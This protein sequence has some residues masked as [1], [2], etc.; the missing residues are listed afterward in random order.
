MPT[1]DESSGDDEDTDVSEDEATMRKS[2]FEVRARDQVDEPTE[3]DDWRQR[4]ERLAQELLRDRPTL[5]PDWIDSKISLRDVSV[6][7]RLPCF[8]CPFKEC[9][10]VLH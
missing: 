5:P 2:D 4:C 9:V 7:I 10:C 3:Q 8:S 6:A 1:L